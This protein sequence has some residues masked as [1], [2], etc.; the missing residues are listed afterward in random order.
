MKRKALSCLMGAILALLFIELSLAASQPSVPAKASV[1]SRIEYGYGLVFYHLE[2]PSGVSSISF[3]LT[4]FTDKLV[5]AFAR[6]EDQKVVMA[7]KINNIISFSFNAPSRKINFT[8]VFD[9]INTTASSVFLKLPVPLSPLGFTTNVTGS[10]TFTT[11]FTL[12]STLG[13]VQGSQVN[14]NI[15]VAPGVFDIINGNA[16]VAQ[17]PVGKVSSLNRTIFIEKDKIVYEDAVEILALSN[18]PITTLSINLPKSYVFDGAEGLLGPYPKNYWHIYNS[19]NSTLVLINLMSSVQLTGQKTILTLQY[20]RNYTNLID[21]Y[22]GLGPTIEKYSIRLCVHGS[23]TVPQNLL[24][25]ETLQGSLHCYV[26]KPVGPLLQAEIYPMVSVSNVSIV[27]TSTLSL[28]SILALGVII[29]GLLAAGIFSVIRLRRSETM[30]AKE[31]ALEKTRLAAETSETIYRNLVRREELLL[32]MLENLKSL[33]ERKAGTA[34]ITAVI[35]EYE[36]RDNIIETETAKI[37]GQ[38]G[39]AGRAIANE[40]SSL[41]N[42]IQQTLREI[43]KLERDY[44]VGKLDKK[45]YKEKAE[46][47]ENDLRKYSQRF[48]EIA[49]KHL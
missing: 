20:H 9:A 46:S 3:N 41:K 1:T 14:Y 21:A 48:R 47:L 22:L 44:R 25:E 33:R 37:L 30:R 19:S 15:T 2:L 12:N 4:G 24:L 32:S 42:N 6:G 49:D 28:T 8:F 39:D 43:E 34:K 36:K 11:G 40:L 29:L 23:L 16:S 5:L 18:F 35:R 31:K 26:L 7:N 10:A 13:K 38:L 45:S 27:P 17:I